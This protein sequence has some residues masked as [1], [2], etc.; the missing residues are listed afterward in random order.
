MSDK[1]TL[2]KIYNLILSETGIKIEKERA[3][4]FEIA[5][6]NRVSKKSFQGEKEYLKFLESHNDE[7]INL[8]SVFT[9]Q[10]T[11]FYRNQ[12]HFDWLK[13]DIL[14][15][16]I[17]ERKKNKNYYLRFLSAG[18]AT[19]E[20]SYTIA[21]IAR[22][23]IPDVSK[24]R[25]DI[26]GVDINELAVSA[27]EKGL[28]S[29]YRFRNMNP[30]Y[31]KKYFDKRVIEGVEYFAIHSDIKKMVK[32]KVVNLIHQPFELNFYQGVD[33][34]FCENVIIYFNQRS[35]EKLISDFHHILNDNGILFLGY[36]ETLNTINHDFSLIWYGNS[37]AFKK[38]SD[39][40]MERPRFD[41]SL[42]PLA[43]MRDDFHGKINLNRPELKKELFYRIL[44]ACETQE[45]NDCIF[46][47]DILEDM[48][49]ISDV[50]YTVKGEYLFDQGKLLEA[51]N[52]CRKAIFIN[53]TLLDPHILLVLIYLGLN[54]LDNALFE[55]KTAAYINSQSVLV[56]YF[57]G[58]Y[59][60]KLGEQKLAENHMRQAKVNLKSNNDQFICEI[61][62][63]SKE[64][65]KEIR[66]EINKF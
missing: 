43:E 6:R 4:D 28:F 14:P 46:L 44:T 63:V 16:L 64:K 55:L 17:E 24:W 40:A 30:E 54:M 10:E 38:Q 39:H 1:D 22:D 3:V 23:L 51:S 15:R 58:K 2:D 37:Y 19:G 29:A 60:M 53:P 8:A 12:S 31:S 27:A 52:I 36:S 47:F 32:F 18:C 57:Y 65:Y 56:Q 50:F 45:L 59:Y 49:I 35:I 48:V 11:S 26:L 7:I 9:I 5:V 21:M 34:I 61:F 33:I 13:K 42:L 25:I 66:A 41:E 20:E 62:P